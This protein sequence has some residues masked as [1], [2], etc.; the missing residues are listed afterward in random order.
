MKYNALEDHQPIHEGTPHGPYL[1]HPELE[2]SSVISPTLYSNADEDPGI[3][4][5]MKAREDLIRAHLDP[6]DPVPDDV[7][8]RNYD[9]LNRVID[10]A[11]EEGA[12]NDVMRN[13]DSD[14]FFRNSRQF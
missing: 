12:E 4:Q 9:R 7:F 14:E 1:P 8:K 6:H 3:Y 5:Y 11:F 2:P 13:I 10:E